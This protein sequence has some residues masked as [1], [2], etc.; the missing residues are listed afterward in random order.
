VIREF[1]DSTSMHEHLA[2][3][4]LQ[5]AVSMIGQESLRTFIE[6]D[7]IPL[8]CKG[9]FVDYS[10]AAKVPKRQQLSSYFIDL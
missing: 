8:V 10:P 6:D 2:M 7:I 4:I 5:F 3:T 1:E 9:L